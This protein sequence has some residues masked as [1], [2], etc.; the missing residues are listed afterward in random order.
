MLFHISYFILELTIE[1][2]YFTKTTVDY[3]IHKTNRNL[4]TVLINV[5]I[6]E[7]GLYSLCEFVFNKSKMRSLRNLTGLGPCFL[8][9]GYLSELE[10]WCNKLDMNVCLTKVIMINTSE[11]LLAAESCRF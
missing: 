2:L 11:E 8:V 4:V 5:S 6:Y 7:I 10:P 3:C 1:Y 9:S